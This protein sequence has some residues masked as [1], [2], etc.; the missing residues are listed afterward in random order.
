MAAYQRRLA[1]VLAA[2]CIA[3]PLLPN[4]AHAAD[5]VRIGSTPGAT[6]DAITAA[7]DDA[8]A[9]G[10]EVKLIEFTDWTLPNEAVNNGDIDL[11]FFQHQ[12]FLDNAIRE[13][14]YQLK[15]IG[16]GLLQNI[17]LYSDRHGSLAALPEGAK[18]AI[19]NDPVNQGRG[20]LLLQ[21]AG[22][23]TLRQGK[24]T[25]ATVNDVVTNPKKLRFYEIEG[26]QLIHSLPDV[27]LAAVWPSYFVNAGRRDQAG[28]ALLY[29]G[30]DDTF[31]AMGFVARSDRADSPALRRF[32]E[33]FQSS[34]SV[35]AAIDE[36][37][38][39]DRN[40]YTLPWLRP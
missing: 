1:A 19:A 33:V 36:R 29:S 2:V 20:L 13:R 14:G 34:A 30:I 7:I 11:N 35:R 40:L 22:L 38:N 39:H 10:L 18:V 32:V 8:R 16:L 25:G 3:L 26:P 24:A 5:V 37:F 27:D 31:Y 15:L 23:I 6:A 9:Q 28:K 21:K 17:G 12:A 4:A